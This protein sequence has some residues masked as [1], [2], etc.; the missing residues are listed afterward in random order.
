M[1]HSANPSNANP[2]TARFW[3]RRPWGARA[4]RRQF[5]PRVDLME[6]RTLLSTLTVMNN[7]DSGSGSLRFE[8]AAASSG[9]TINFSSNLNGQTIALTSGPLTLG[10][11]MTIDG[12]GADKLRSAEAGP[13]A[14]SWS[15]QA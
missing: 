8:I 9:D 14:Y 11:N 3:A 12:L 10:V 5:L 4:R 13:R 2:S 7:K 1:S 6:D 15:P